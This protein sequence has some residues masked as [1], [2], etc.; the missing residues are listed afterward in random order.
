MVTELAPSVPAA[1]L[2]FVRLTVTGA[3]PGRRVWTP[4]YC[5]DTGS[6]ETKLTDTVEG[7]EKGVV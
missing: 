1:V 2:S 7:P 5:R 4:V 6:R 3:A